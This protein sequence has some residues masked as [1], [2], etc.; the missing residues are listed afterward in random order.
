MNL[1][2]IR[3]NIDKVDSEL[4]ELFIKRMELVHR[5]YE[6]KSENN[7]PVK[8]NDREAAIIEKRTADLEKFRE[9]T[10][11]FF[12]DLID[13]SCK[14][15][16]QRLS[17]EKKLDSSFTFL[18]REDFLRGVKKVAYQGIKGSYGSEMAMRLFNDKELI[19][20]KSFLEVCESVKSGEVCLGVLPV[21]NLSAGSVSG[22]YDLIY[23]NGLTVVME[24]ELEIRHCLLGTGA[25]SEVERVKSHP[26]ALSQCSRFIKEHNFETVEGVNTAVCA[27]EASRYEDATLGVISSKINSEYYNLRILK[28]NIS[29]IEDNKT[30][31]VVV[32]RERVILDEPRK[33]SLV[34]TLP[35][36]TGSLARVLGDF[37]AHSFNLTKIESRP[38]KSNMWEYNFYVDIE[39]SLK[40]EKTKEHL[41]KISYLFDEIKI[42]GNC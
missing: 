28:E 7:L 22:V 42:L 25:F 36:K 1:D 33:I 10:G 11:E 3:V 23:E 14:Y 19:S 32:S 39:G 5:V 31:F 21:E 13:I 38:L 41:E 18:K 34:F 27:Y 30:R 6:Y 15:Q 20:K 26:Q 37:S 40:D 8:N 9:E 35:H 12:K 2:E 29:D 17:K 24:E 4:R 16:E